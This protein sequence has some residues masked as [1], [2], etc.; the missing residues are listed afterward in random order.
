[1]ARFINIIALLL[2]VSVSYSQ[3][4][5]LEFKAKYQQAKI[6]LKNNNIEQ[7]KKAFEYL[8][9][10]PQNSYTPYLYYYLAM[11]QHKLNDYNEC[12]N[13]LEQISSKY[14]LWALNDD[15]YYLTGINYLKKNEIEK[16]LTFLNKIKNKDFE[17]KIS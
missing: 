4:P 8:I 15:Y 16:S 6:N 3:S 7:A 12:E 14:T 11:A 5:S 9:S 13:T 2:L 10:T 17:N 1:M